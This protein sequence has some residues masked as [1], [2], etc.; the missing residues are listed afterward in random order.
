MGDGVDARLLVVSHCLLNPYSSVKGRRTPKETARLVVGRAVAEGVGLVQLPCPEFTIEGPNRWAKSY[1]QYDQTFFRDHCARLVEPVVD[2]LREYVADGTR[3]LGV[4]GV[5]G[6]PSCGAYAVS[7]GE[8]WGGCF[9]DGPDGAP[10]RPGKSGKVTGRGIFLA[11]L[12]GA[13][14]AEGWEI[15]VTGV[16]KDSADT[17]TLEGFARTVELMVRG[18]LAGGREE[19][20]AD[21]FVEAEA[22]DW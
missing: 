1:E 2:Q 5:E 3:V 20:T 9:D 22:E 12:A 14:E 18:E 19:P 17:E 6:S 21:G 15:P 8:E 11:A 13:L 7:S 4:I 10:W 16:P